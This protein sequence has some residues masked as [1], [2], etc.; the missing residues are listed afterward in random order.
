MSMRTT[1]KQVIKYLKNLKKRTFSAYHPPL[2][3]CIR[4]LEMLTAIQNGT[5][6]EWRKKH[7]IL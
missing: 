7:E 5:Y 1:R 6:Q 2:N 3:D 4:C